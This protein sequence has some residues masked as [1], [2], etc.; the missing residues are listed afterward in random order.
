MALA[1]RTA[2]RSAQIM[3]THSSLAA[4]AISLAV[5]LDLA[6]VALAVV[7]LFLFFLCN[8]ARSGCVL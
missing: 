3:A 8:P 7:S 6:L 1:P 4:T 5:L 2:V